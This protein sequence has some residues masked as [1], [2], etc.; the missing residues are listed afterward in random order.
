MTDLGLDAN[1]IPFGD[2][3]IVRGWMSLAGLV[4]APDRTH[5]ARPVRGLDSPRRE[6]SGTTLYGW[7]RQRYGTAERFFQECWIVSYCPLLMFDAEG[8]NVTPADFRKGSG[9]L[10][11]L[12]GACDEHLAT[13]LKVFAPPFTIGVGQFAAKRAALVVER[14]SLATRVG[15]VTHPSPQTRGHWGPDGWAGLAETELR[16]L[17]AGMA[18][19]GDVQ[20]EIRYNS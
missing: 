10:A 4:Q 19:A 7:A 16:K 18:P 13:V 1:H 5:P 11:A 14:L 17:E 6:E 20:P 12:E 3:A 9:Q 8:K 2:P 15:C